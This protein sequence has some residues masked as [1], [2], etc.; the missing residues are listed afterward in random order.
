MLGARG[1]ASCTQP[2][3]TRQLGSEGAVVWKGSPG[4]PS[5][6]P[7]C[8]P[9]HPGNSACLIQGT[10]L[11]SRPTQE[12]HLSP[13]RHEHSAFSVEL[14][15]PQEAPSE[16]HLILL[17]GSQSSYMDDTEQAYSLYP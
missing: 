4:L 17:P 5:C 6:C 13:Q 12:P 2:H 3:D 11:S 1:S 8:P 7:L 10:L 14:F 15:S 16:N 9:P